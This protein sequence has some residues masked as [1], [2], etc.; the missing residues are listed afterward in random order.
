MLNISKIVEC[1]STYATS[2]VHCDCQE[3]LIREMEKFSNPDVGTKTLV[4]KTS[5]MQNTLCFECLDKNRCQHSYMNDNYIFL[6]SENHV[7]RYR[8]KRQFPCLPIR[9]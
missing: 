3:L 2:N 9:R 8:K 6:H 1:E 4:P 5:F 7:D